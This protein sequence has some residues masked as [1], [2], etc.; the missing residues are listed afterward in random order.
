MALREVTVEVTAK[1]I[2]KFQA[3]SADEVK[4]KIANVILSDVIPDDIN[5]SVIDVKPMEVNYEDLQH[6]Q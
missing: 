2:I 1:Y 3:N 6:K 4:K 5:Y